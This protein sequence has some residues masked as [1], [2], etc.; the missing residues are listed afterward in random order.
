M[1]KMKQNAGQKFRLGAGI[2]LA[3]TAVGC[4]VTTVPLTTEER[5]QRI[6]TD[7]KQL[8]IA[9]EPVTQA[10]SLWEAMARAI[11]Y[12]MDHRVKLMEHAVASRHGEVARTDLLPHITA[13]AGYT[14]RSNDSGARSQSLLTGEESLEPSTSQ[15]RERQ[16]ADL[17]VLWNVLDFGV[18]YATAKQRQD[19]IRIAEER[20]R[21]VIQNIMQDVID[22]F[23]RAHNAQYLVPQMDDLIAETDES[24]AQSKRLIAE[25]AQ[26][27]REA[28]EYQRNLMETRAQLWEMRERMALATTRLATLMNLRPGTDYTLMLPAQ[29]MVPPSSSMDIENMERL[30]LADRPELR[31]EDYRLRI[32]Q[33]D[34]RKA[35]LRMFP[36]VEINAGAHYDSNKFLFNDDWSDVGLAISWNLFNVFGGK[37]AKRFHEAEVELA[38]VRRMALSMAVMTQV[39]LSVQRYE[40]AR[41][42]YRVAADLAMVNEE[43]LAVTTTG[44][45]TQTKF[46]VIHARAVALASD[47]RQRLAYAETQNAMA[48]VLNSLGVN[49]IPDEV[50]S[51]RIDALASAI[52]THWTGIVG[53]HFSAA[54]DSD[55]DGDLDAGVQTG[56]AVETNVDGQETSR[57]ND[58]STARAP[59][60]LTVVPMADAD[61]PELDFISRLTDLTVDVPLALDKQKG[62]GPFSDIVAVDYADVPELDFISRLTDLTVDVP[63]ALDKQ[64]GKPQFPGALLCPGVEPSTTAGVGDLLSTFADRIRTGERE[65]TK[66]NTIPHVDRLEGTASTGLYILS[67]GKPDV[68][69]LYDPAVYESDF[70][71]KQ[72]NS[73][74]G[75]LSH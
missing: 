12:N 33:L 57:L 25:G 35:M 2:A 63:L 54:T 31:E 24:I 26:R 65:A 40:L 8:F 23:W 41:E 19:E 10:V 48:R 68:S 66:H 22:A 34:V 11:K 9:Q 43:L 28:L 30:A 16:L 51:H 53:R 32:S 70:G 49:P 1:L 39:R 14:N 74:S 37:A 20:R 44:T 5:T 38:D 7:L 64:E 46:D 69:S 58:A 42:R 62:E 56:V 15:E 75:A 71:L 55:P 13:S 59:G 52:E 18:S 21:K 17:N 45:Q 27:K 61:V 60:N 36:G 29:P 47:V 73:T 4:A 6:T 3:V 72:T 50:R 67:L